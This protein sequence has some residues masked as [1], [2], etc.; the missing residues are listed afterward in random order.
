MR[1]LQS[2]H[3]APGSDRRV[4]KVRHIS[5]FSGQAYRRKNLPI[6]CYVTK[7]NR[8]HNANASNCLQLS[9][10]RTLSITPT[11]RSSK[12]LDIGRWPCR[13]LGSIRSWTVKQCL[14]TCIPP[15]VP[16]SILSNPDHQLTRTLTMDKT[17]ETDDPS[18]NIPKDILRFLNQRLKPEELSILLAKKPP[19]ST[20]HRKSTDR[21]MES[22]DKVDKVCQC[23]PP[24]GDI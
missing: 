1:L 6:V 8:E 11:P 16:S 15:R 14:Y 19:A 17:E 13:C 12:G 22:L 5:R 18:Y 24:C 7:G 3:S 4:P 23:L 2:H 9:V 10:M 21:Q 20:L